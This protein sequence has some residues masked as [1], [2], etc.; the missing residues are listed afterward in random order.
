MTPS[1]SQGREAQK[2]VVNDVKVFF[3]VK[4]SGRPAIKI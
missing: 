3:S 1:L 4:S 2:L